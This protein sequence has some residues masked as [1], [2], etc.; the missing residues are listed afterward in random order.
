MPT[1]LELAGVKHG[2]ALPPLD[3]RS[4]APLL[5]DD[6]TAA[7]AEAKAAAEAAW[8]DAVYIE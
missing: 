5:L 4:L 6:G 1:W 8:R 2:A 3:G 7:A